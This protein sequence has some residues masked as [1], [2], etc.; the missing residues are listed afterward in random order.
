M[1]LSKIEQILKRRKTIVLYQENPQWIGDYNAVYQM[2][3]MPKLDETSLCYLFE[4]T[5]EQRQKFNVITKAYAPVEHLFD[6]HHITDNEVSTQ[7]LFSLYSDGSVFI[8]IKTSQGVRFIAAEYLAPFTKDDVT[9]YERTL[10]GH[11]YF[12][13]KKGLFIRAVILPCLIK[14]NGEPVKQFTAELHALMQN[15]TNDCGALDLLGVKGESYA[16]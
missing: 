11:I 16:E 14:D 9:V 3:N 1:K 13:V 12:V 7:P 8:P 4:I 5:E 10:N 2:T 6:D 15:Y